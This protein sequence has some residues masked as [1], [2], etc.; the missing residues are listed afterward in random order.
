M[1]RSPR[2]VLYTRWKEIPDPPRTGGQRVA[3][4]HVRFL[5]RQGY[6]VHVVVT[7][8]FTSHPE[9]PTVR[10]RKLDRFIQPT[11]YM[12]VPTI[13]SGRMDELPR[14]RKVIL[15]QNGPLFVSQLAPDIPSYPWDHEDV[16]ASIC[17]SDHDVELMRM[18]GARG[19]VHRVFNRVDCSD[20]EPVPWEDRENLICTP[21][22]IDRKNRWHSLVLAHLAR[23]N[24]GLRIVEILGM[25]PREA[26]ETLARSKVFLFPSI[27]E[28]FGLLPL[29]AAYLRVPVI[30]FR[31][32]PCDEF[33]PEECLFE[34]GDFRSAWEAIQRAVR[35]PD[36][37]TSTLDEAER[38]AHEY[39]ADR[40]ER[41]VLSTWRSITGGP[42]TGEEGSGHPG[43]GFDEARIV[44][45]RASEPLGD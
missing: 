27:A 38:T 17:V 31:H 29:E 8:R 14:C 6:D 34:P 16:V 9:I 19:P 4:Q 37:W 30:A 7:G 39:T 40:Q 3:L 23:S 20:V 2:I 10:L 24:L 15:N 42:G 5:R 21:P 25:K 28:G 22:L 45:E 26:M 1:A 41:S 18:M 32:Q 35:E 36:T 11:D 44:E 43:S 13:H 12:V 33:L